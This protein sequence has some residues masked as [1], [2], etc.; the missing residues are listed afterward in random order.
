MQNHAESSRNYIQKTFVN[1]KRAK[2]DEKSEFG[3]DQT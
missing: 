2:L 1:P 3:R